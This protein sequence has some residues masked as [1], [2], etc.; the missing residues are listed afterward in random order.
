MSAGDNRSVWRK[1][2][3]EGEHKL[4]CQPHSEK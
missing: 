2:A 4:E 3:T 1:K